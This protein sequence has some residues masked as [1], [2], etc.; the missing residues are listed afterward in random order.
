M[1]FHD[2]VNQGQRVSKSRLYHLYKRA[3]GRHSRDDMGSPCVRVCGGN[4]GP[5][6]GQEI[7]KGVKEMPPGAF[8]PITTYTASKVSPSEI[9]EHFHS[10]GYSVQLKI[11]H[12]CRVHLSIVM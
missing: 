10:P 7:P 11:S 8:I 12:I 3:D 5:R 6:K 9:C 2:V 1:H 4:N